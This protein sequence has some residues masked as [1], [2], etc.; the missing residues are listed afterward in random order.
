MKITPNARPRSDQIIRFGDI[1]DGPDLTVTG[2]AYTGKPFR[3][4]R[5]KI[6]FSS[7]TGVWECSGVQISGHLLKQ[8]GTPGKVEASATLSD[9]A[10]PDT[11]EWVKY[12]VAYLRPEEPVPTVVTQP[13][14]LYV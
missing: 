5:Y 11:P 3:A 1:T 14:D 4:E 10:A 12:L 8:D 6:T 9:L 7:R 13:V 2:Y